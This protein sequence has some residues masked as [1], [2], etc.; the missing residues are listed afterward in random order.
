LLIGFLECQDGEGAHGNVLCE[1]AA[2]RCAEWF[3]RGTVRRGEV[4]EVHP[5]GVPVADLRGIGRNQ[6]GQVERAEGV[7]D[8]GGVEEVAHDT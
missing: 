1:K 7:G 3:G 2:D 8:R 6:V 4:E 5:R